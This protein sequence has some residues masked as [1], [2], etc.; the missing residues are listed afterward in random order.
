M[1]LF[2][3]GSHTFLN[4]FIRKNKCQRILEIGVADGENAKSMVLVASENLP[5][6]DVEYY[7]VDTFRW[8]NNHQITRIRHKLRKIGCQVTLFQGDSVHILPKII[9]KLPLMDLIFIDGGHSY[10]TVKSDW[11]HSKSLMHQKTAVFFHNYDYAGPKRVVETISRT[12]YKVI[13][14]YPPM[15]YP[16]ALVKITK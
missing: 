7:G 6:S 15:D 1:N 11:D 16:S 14:I 9:T 4:E 2:G 8:R 5:I 3:Y 12:N 10:L 13:K